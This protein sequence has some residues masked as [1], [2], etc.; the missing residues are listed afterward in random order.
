[1]GITNL[2]MLFKMHFSPAKNLMYSRKSVLPVFGA[3]TGKYVCQHV[4]MLL[5]T[6]DA[7]AFASP[8]HRICHMCAD[9]CMHVCVCVCVCVYIKTIQMHQTH[10]NADL[11]F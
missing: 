3:R 11:P 9:V 5:K 1:M 6:L 8:K 10:F 4:Q 2:S 7:L